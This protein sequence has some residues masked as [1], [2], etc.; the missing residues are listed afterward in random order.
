M[1]PYPDNS[2]IMKV[3]V[4]ER[5]QVMKKVVKEMLEC[6]IGI[7]ELEEVQESCLETEQFE[8][9]EAIKQA[10]KDYRKRFNQ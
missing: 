5:I 4:S 3:P 9:S 6:G 2:V 7:I 10:I 8:V 1:H